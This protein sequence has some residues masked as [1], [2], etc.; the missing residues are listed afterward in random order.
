MGRT[1]KNRRIYEPKPVQKIELSENNVKK[2]AIAAVLFLIIGV[3]LLV[4]CFMVFIR[5]QTGWTTIETTNT[6]NDSSEFIFQ[7][8]LGASG[9]SADA[10]SRAVKQIYNETAVK[11]YQ[12]FHNSESFEG[13]ANIYWINSKPNVEIEIDPVLYN[14]FSVFESTGSRYLYLAPMYQHYSNLFYCLDDTQTVDFDPVTN[15][16]IRDEFK[17]TAEFANDPKSV[18]LKLLGDNKVELFVSDSYLK[19]AEEQAITDFIGF[20]W[21]KNAFEVDYIADTLIQKGYTFGS[22]S[23]YD[24]FI[25]NMD[26]SGTSYSLNIFDK[27]G[28]TVYQPAV[29]QYSGAKSIVYLRN[30]PM[31]E[32]DVQHYYGLSNGEIRTPYLDI[33]DGL[34]RNSVDNL[35]SYSSDRKCSE[36][37]LQMLP[38]YISESFS[39]EKLK[40]LEEK[41]IYSVYCDDRRVKYNDEELILTGLYD[42]NG[43]TYTKELF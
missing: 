20:S 40:S 29:M 24:G 10:E 19:F 27:Q 25:R 26:D 41:D 6:L 39:E 8:N 12:L 21:F 9:I 38:V 14:A 5:P 2:R 4:Y 31:S 17:R 13:V 23:T 36:I 3:A 16:S 32:L 35:V 30:F 34:P 11:A 22:I 42:L 15:D 1:V 43:I 37:L 33:K 18:Q 7:Y 28:E